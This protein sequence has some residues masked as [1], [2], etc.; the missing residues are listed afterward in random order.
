MC[1][2]F[3]AQRGGKTIYDNCACSP[4][5]LHEHRVNAKSL[6]RKRKRQGGRNVRPKKARA[7]KGAASER[8][9]LDFDTDDSEESSATGKAG[10]GDGD[11]DSD[12]DDAASSSDPSDD[13]EAENV[14]QDLASDNENDLLPEDSDNDKGPTGPIDS[15]DDK[16]P[17]GAP[18]QNY[19]KKPVNPRGCSECIAR[20]VCPGSPPFPS[21]IG[22][23]PAQSPSGAQGGSFL[24]ARDYPAARHASITMVGMKK[25]AGSASTLRLMIRVAYCS[26]IAGE[27]DSEWWD[28]PRNGN[29]SGYTRKWGEPMQREFQRLADNVGARLPPRHR[30]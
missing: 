21:L 26:P 10:D 15:E 17:A 27:P 12:G 11:G 3:G 16:P 8:R 18:Q 1:A 22:Q 14:P 20:L 9:K 24:R 13:F 7:R 2:A 6:Q 23:R 19:S 5:V 4:L 25:M 29:V 28:V 30:G